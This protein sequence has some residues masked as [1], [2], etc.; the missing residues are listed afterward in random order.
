MP[1][2]TDPNQQDQG[3]QNGVVYRLDVSDGINTVTNVAEPMFLGLKDPQSLGI[4][5]ARQ[6]G[7]IN[8]F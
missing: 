1:F 6:E 2:E 3:G 5:E 4:L 7:L 8:P